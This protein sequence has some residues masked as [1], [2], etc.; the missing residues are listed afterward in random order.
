MDDRLTKYQFEEM[1]D[2]FTKIMREYH[3]AVRKFN[4]RLP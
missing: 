2:A 4:E 3:S 1:Q